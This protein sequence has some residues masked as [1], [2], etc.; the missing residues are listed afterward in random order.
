MRRLFRQFSFP[1]GIPSHVAPRDARLDPRGRRARLLALPRLRRRLRQPRPARRAASSATARRRPGRSPP[2]G[3]PTSSST[4]RA[5]GRC[6][7]S[8]TSTATRSP[9]RPCSPASR[10]AELRALLEG[11]GYAPR[12]VE[13]DDPAEMHQLMA[14]TLDEVA[15]RDRRRSSGARARTASYERPALA[16]DRAAHAQGL[17]RAED[18]RRAARR[19]HLSLAP[20]AARRGRR[21]SR[22]PRPARGMDALLPARGAVRRG[23]RA[24]WRSSR[25]SRRRASGGWAP[26]RTP[27]AACCCATSSCPTSANYAVDVARPGASSS[28]ATRVLGAFLRDVIRPNPETLPHLRPRRDRLQPPRR[29]VRGDQPRRGRPRYCPPTTTWRPTGA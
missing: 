14:A 23:R 4:P 7:R 19:G 29:R 13:G 25:R 11:Y 1:G 10:H 18:R 6:C 24:A 27:T 20:G 21:Q 22:A 12:F 28:E 5:T 16:D 15:R 26:T 8:C 3:T 2:A 9:T 17:D